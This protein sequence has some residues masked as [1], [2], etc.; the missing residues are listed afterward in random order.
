MTPPTTSSK[1]LPLLSSPGGVSSRCP[2]QVYIDVTCYNTFIDIM[3]HLPPP[4][5]IFPN[6]FTSLSIYSPI[7]NSRE[8][9]TEVCLRFYSIFIWLVGVS[10]EKVRALICFRDTPFSFLFFFRVRT[11]PGVLGMSGK[12]ERTRHEEEREV[13]PWSVSLGTQIQESER[14]ETRR[15][16]GR[17][18]V[19]DSD[20]MRVGSGNE[21][22]NSS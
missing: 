4:P 7:R 18:S 1:S 14:Y 22:R 15:G 17:G 13:Y 5:V 8:D 16:P 10:S 6:C 19:R 12:S 2:V 3:F 9:K 11:I 20:L 21:N